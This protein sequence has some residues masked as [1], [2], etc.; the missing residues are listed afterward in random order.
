MPFVDLRAQYRLLE[1]Q[2]DERIRRVLAHGQYVMGPEVGEL[3]EALREYV[4]VRHAIGCASGTDALLLPLMALGVGPGDAVFT[5]P[6]TFIATAEVIALL[7]AT[8]VFVDID[9]ETYN[10]DPVQLDRAVRAL[11]AGDPTV[12][13]LPSPAA[14]WRQEGAYPAGAGGAGAGW[15]QE[16]AYP[17]GSGGAGAGRAPLVPKGV[18]AVDLYGLPADY[19]ALAGVCSEHGLV[20]LEDAA[21]AFG[22][23]HNGRRACSFGDAGA[24]SFFPAKPLGCYGDGGMVFTD[25]DD[26]AEAMRSL[27]N[28]GQGGDRYDNVRVG[29]NARLDTVQ[30]A[31]TLAKFEVFPGELERRRDV[32]RLYTELFSRAEGVRAP[33]VPARL[34][35]AWGQYTIR[36]PAAERSAAEAALK[37][38]GVPA[39]IY[40]PRPLHLQG[41]FRGLGYGP[42]DFPQAERASREV[43]SLPF[44]P[45]LDAGA[46]REIA[47]TLCTAVRN[48]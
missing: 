37:K 25:R 7:G 3:E 13:P 14:R 9:A 20:L 2:I 42:G 45:Y 12:H 5:T 22:A 41:A 18:I 43:L 34:R 39:M 28:H 4:G 35:S 6:F 16:G 27:R 44:G 31:V 23:E 8:P 17:A 29:L 19:D 36:L 1:R 11:Q 46:V 47:H 24:T 40:Y 38:V 33:A 32:A 21:Q 48:S 30:A 15:R 26:L 10:L